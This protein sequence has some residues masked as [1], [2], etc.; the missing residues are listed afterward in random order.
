LGVRLAASAITTS[1]RR[2]EV[3]QRLESVEKEHKIQHAKVEQ[4]KKQLESLK[5]QGTS[6]PKKSW[7]KSAGYRV[8][9]LLSLGSQ[10]SIKALASGTIKMLLGNND[11]SDK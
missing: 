6:L 1:R 4:L 5:G 11:S 2:S 3:V 9:D 7:L 10:E 8:L